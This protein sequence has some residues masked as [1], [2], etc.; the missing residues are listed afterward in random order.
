MST[1]HEVFVLERMKIGAGI[2]LRERVEKHLKNEFYNKILPKILKE[3]DSNLKI[4]MANTVDGLELKLIFT[5][6]EGE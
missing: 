6:E 4:E 3:V 2:Q 5:K 1:D